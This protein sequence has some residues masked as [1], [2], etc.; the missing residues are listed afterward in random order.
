MAMGQT[1]SFVAASG[2]GR[3]QGVEVHLS[4]DGDRRVEDLA[5]ILQRLVAAWFELG[6]G[7]IMLPPPM[8]PAGAD[9]AQFEAFKP[10]APANVSHAPGQY[11]GLYVETI[12]QQ[13][14][15]LKALLNARA[16]TVGPWPLVRAE[17]ELAGR[18]AWLLEPDLGPRSGERRV[19]RFYL[20]SVSS[21]QRGRFTA[22]KFDKAQAKKLKS[23]RDG[24]IA[25]ARSVF[26]VFAP[27]L[28]GIN[29][30]ETWELR[31]EILPGLGAGVSKFVDLCLSTGAG[32]YDFLSDYS[33]PSLTAT[34]L[35]TTAVD[36]G[37]V[38]IRPWLT[39]VDTVE[40]Q[41][42]LACIIFYK[43]CHLLA[44][45]YALDDSPLER[46]AASVPTDW[47]SDGVGAEVAP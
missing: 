5:A 21:L 38:M 17:L 46:W 6:R 44:G 40:E 45:Y 25:E 30:I 8:S 31:G 13:L 41:V 10:N 9:V 39:T 3:S 47:F 22:G 27:D 16:L 14:L 32:L 43:A 15:A 34:L 29:K 37:G 20:E 7:L 36:I 35:Q 12:S 4:D 42:R 19:A 23:E 18:V 24:K 28:S 26:G 33:H 1:G 11:A 2:E